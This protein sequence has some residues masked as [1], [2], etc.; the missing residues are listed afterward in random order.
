L[1]AWTANRVFCVSVCAFVLVKQV[2]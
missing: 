2:N 1:S